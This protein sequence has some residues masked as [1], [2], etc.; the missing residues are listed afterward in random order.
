M[1]FV[2]ELTKLIILFTVSAEYELRPMLT[3]AGPVCQ[4]SVYRRHLVC[5]CT[6]YPQQ[7][8]SAVGLIAMQLT[9]KK[10]SQ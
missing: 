4:H 2:N 10:L 9:M 5:G 1:S 7:S 3:V 8:M 6:I